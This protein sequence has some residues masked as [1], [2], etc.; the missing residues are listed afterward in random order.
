[1]ENVEGVVLQDQVASGA[2]APMERPRVDQ[3]SQGDLTSPVQNAAT[4][5]TLKEY[6]APVSI[7]RIEHFQSIPD[8]K[9][10]SSSKN[11]IIVRTLN[12][13]RH[14]CIDG[15]SLIQKAITRGES[16]ITCHVYE[17]QSYSELE[18]EIRKVEVRMR[19]PGG[20]P[21]YPEISRNVKILCE[22]L[23]ASDP[24]VIAFHHGGNRRPAA[25]TSNKVDNVIDVIASRLLKSRKTIAGYLSHSKYLT[26][27][28]IEELIEKDAPKQFFEKAQVYK[29]VLLRDLQ[30]EGK[31]EP[32][33]SAA[34]SEKILGWRDEYLTNKTLTYFPSDSSVPLNQPQEQKK[35]FKEEQLSLFEHWKGDTGGPVEQPAT[36]EDLKQEI[37][38]SLQRIEAGVEVQGITPK[39]LRDL[40]STEIR[41]LAKI[42]P[43]LQTLLDNEVASS[44][45]TR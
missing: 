37:K 42:I 25:Q 27:E 14:H 3:D 40:L 28:A 9:I 10:E 30:H 1:L 33:I 43:R 35:P 17:V 22:H 5:E 39:S 41:T 12:D 24:N 32:E 29:R 4:V 31:T 26:N 7:E 36:L 11:P 34:I 20:R 19:P 38:G 21:T 18:L 16:E 8:Y 6:T 2:L 13:D 23:L 45:E 44:K 15:W